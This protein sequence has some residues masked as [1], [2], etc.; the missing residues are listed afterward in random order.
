VAGFTE[1]ISKQ[2]KQQLLPLPII[3]PATRIDAAI[4][5]VKLLIYCEI[6]QGWPSAGY[7]FNSCD[8]HRFFV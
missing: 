4:D 3:T 7:A 6:E 2:A 1:S 8:R 5:E